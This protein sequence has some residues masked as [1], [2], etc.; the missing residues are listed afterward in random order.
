MREPT[1]PAA[2]RPSAWS[3]TLRRSAAVAVVLTALGVLAAP[4]IAPSAS[5]AAELG[6]PYVDQFDSAAGGT[7]SGD[8]VVTGGR[9]RLTDAVRNQAGS[10]STDDTFPSD[11]GL[12]IEFEYAMYNDVGDPGADGLL[13]SLS[14]GAAPQGV[15]A[16]GAA[17]GYA[18]RS[19]TNQGGGVPCDL[20]GMPGGFAGIALDHYGNFS[21]PLNE[22]GPG[23]QEQFVV[24]R[25]SGNGVSGYRYVD[26]VRAPGGTA[27][28]GSSTRTV[29]V[30]LQPGDA[31][32]LF[33]SVRIDAGGGMRPVL[34]RVPLHGDGQAP[35]PETLRL[36]FAGATGSHL[37]VHEVDALRVWQPAD[38]AVEHDMPPTVSAGGAVEYAV[39]ASNVGSNPSEPSALDVDVPDALQDVTWT[40]APG[41]G[42]GT[43]CG[44]PSGTGD[45]EVPLD[46]P[47]GGEATVR[48]TGTLPANASGT[49]D[50]TA[51]IAPAPS[52]ADVN[53]A[54]NVSTASATV[55]P[56]APPEA[57]VETDKSVTPSTDV[58]PGDEVEYLVT[59]T[60]RGPAVA[61]A[62][63]AVDELPEQMRFVGSDDGC[64][65]AGQVVTC[66]SGRALAAGEST[67]FRIRAVL[68][69][70]YH[71]DGSDVV[72]VATASSPTD[73]DGG[74]PSPAVDIEVV[75][76][77]DEG[78]DDEG[79]GDAG[80]GDAGPGDSGPGRG[81]A[82]AGD[83]RDGSSTSPTA[84]GGHGTDRSGA[85]AYTG[86]EDLGLLAAVGAVMA[87]A[88]G[89]CW[90]LARRRTRRRAGT[91]DDQATTR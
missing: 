44:A 65:A 81:D 67:A 61:Q 58:A 36:G 32:E 60:N 68:D 13:L 89:A 35:L 74:D 76:P 26:G 91:P 52:M 3:R 39:T 64:T 53:E 79:P 55:A 41:S 33:V 25:G 37:D 19:S 49:L 78:P 83:G 63:G 75:V 69:P 38:L 62:V 56:G 14:D 73:P 10:W 54:D 47:R 29:R 70:A 2:A 15:G 77:D 4:T 43:A 30:T 12:E 71:G 28:E 46:L 42:D 34:D 90:W 57:H 48:I 85:L 16:Y 31:G 20:P 51:R 72:N 27:T 88:G 86:T 9:L 84:G 7:L 24:V 80:P 18:C 17:L 11:R 22:S 87:A 59:A 5:S 45:V 1:T 40:C 6:F 66:A 82:G 23:A 8:A 21:L 50:S